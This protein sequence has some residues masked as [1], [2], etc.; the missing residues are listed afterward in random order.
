MPLYELKIAITSL[1]MFFYSL[2]ITVLSL[3]GEYNGNKEI[4]SLSCSGLS[5]FTAQRAT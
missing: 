4:Q 5:P 3:F 2:L 1:I